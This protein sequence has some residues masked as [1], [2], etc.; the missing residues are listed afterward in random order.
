ME[1]FV[2]TYL[3]KSPVQGELNDAATA[4]LDKLMINAQ[5]T[6]QHIVKSPTNNAI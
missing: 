5:A 2:P 6:S 3:N 4:K 1:G